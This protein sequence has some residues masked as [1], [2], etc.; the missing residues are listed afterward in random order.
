M[1]SV[2]LWLVNFVFLVFEHLAWSVKNFGWKTSK[3][4]TKY[5]TVDTI[6]TAFCVGLAFTAW[7]GFKTVAW[8]YY[9]TWSQ[10]KH[11]VW[12]IVKRHLCFCFNGHMSGWVTGNK[13][14]KI[15]CIW[16]EKSLAT[17]E[18]SLWFCKPYRCHEVRLKTSVQLLTPRWAQEVKIYKFVKHISNYF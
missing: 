8:K 16:P 1:F 2:K 3:S 6:F 18:Y 12:V 15:N 11:I 14:Q 4:S 17:N 9:E 7:Q 13:K 5:K 10:I